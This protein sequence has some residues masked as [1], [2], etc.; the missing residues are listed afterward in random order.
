LADLL[1]VSEAQARILANFQVVGTEEVALAACARR[2]LAEDIHAPGD[3]PPF[4]NS[5]MDGFA[6]ISA[7]VRTA[8]EGSPVQLTIVADIPA[9][10]RAPGKIAP[11]QAARIMTGAPLP[12]G[13]DAV[14]PVEQTN[15]APQAAG[16]AQQ[17][18]IPGPVLVSQ[19]VYQG[20]YIRPRG[21]DVQAGQRL[22][23]RGRRIQPQDVGIIASAGRAAV[24]VYRKPR[25][26]LF[27]TGDEL[28][29]PGVS[30]SPGQ[31][32]DSNRFM[33]AALLEREGAQVIQLGAAADDPSAVRALLERAAAEG[34]DLIITSAGVSVGAFDY[35]RQVISENGSLDFWRVNMRPGKPLAFGSFA[36]VPLIG[37]PGNPVSAF[38]GCIVFGLPVVQKLSGQA[39][40]SPQR[41]RAILSEAIE[42]DGR[43]SYLRASVHRQGGQLLAA[44][45]GHQ[46]SGNL[47]SLVQANALL[48][49]PSGVK[50]LPSGTE[51]DIWFLDDK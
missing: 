28:V 5:S 24:H 21:Q 23:Q 26:A 27:S 44:L 50:S 47:F 32:Y 42:S 46:G 2:I 13:A 48:I 4:T 10:E 41:A 9:G 6:V 14:V 18:A 35:V 31:I 7:D 43:E 16:T 51:V 17:V 19:A 29:S 11:G 38:V 37:L 40:Q 30:L 49:V 36:G 20:D 33:L 1:S 22:L 25:V 34:A 8:S 45:S 15:F 39:Q 12:E 3:L